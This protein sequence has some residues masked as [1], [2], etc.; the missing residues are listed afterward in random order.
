MTLES[1]IL[2]KRAESGKLRRIGWIS[3]IS[4]PLFV[5]LIE[6]DLLDRIIVVN[7]EERLSIEEILAHPWMNSEEVEK[8]EE[9]KKE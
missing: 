5:F 6:L 3:L 9:E 7:P 1:C 4:L 8:K 2:F